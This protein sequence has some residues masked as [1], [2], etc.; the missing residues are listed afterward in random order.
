MVLGLRTISRHGA[1]S[2]VERVGTQP[3]R[4]VSE[5]E[6]FYLPLPEG[7]RLHAPSELLQILIGTMFH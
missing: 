3:P 2:L 4:G 1:F 5:T 7:I 6:F